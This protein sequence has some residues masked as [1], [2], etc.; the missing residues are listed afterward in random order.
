MNLKVY[1]LIEKDW[2][3]VGALPGAPEEDMDILDEVHELYPEALRI[4]IARDYPARV[5]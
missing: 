1:V 3:E 4:R 2:H 5:E